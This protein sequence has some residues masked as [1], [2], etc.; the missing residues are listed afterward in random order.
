MSR[1][2]YLPP[3]L[4]VMLRQVPTFTL[5]WPGKP[6]NKAKPSMSVLPSIRSKA[7]L[8]M[9]CRHPMLCTWQRSS[10]ELRLTM[11]LIELS[12][13][14]WLVQSRHL[15]KSR[16][17]RRRGTVRTWSALL[18]SL[19]FGALQQQPHHLEVQWPP[20][21]GFLALA[22]AAAATADQ[23]SSRVVGSLQVCNL[24]RTNRPYH[25]HMPQ[26]V[27]MKGTVCSG[28]VPHTRVMEGQRSSA[29]PFRARS[30]L[31]SGI[32]IG[33]LHCQHHP[34]CQADT[35]RMVPPMKRHHGAL[36]NLLSHR[37]A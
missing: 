27:L 21:V 17:L 37:L 18:E 25:D 16:A 32:C 1:L 24:Q 29:L 5:I 35:P 11:M 31:E 22:R 2:P 23:A 30:H 13:K 26:Q 4:A 8:P 12:S 20:N 28:A 34:P 3:C 33:R 9:P 10:N 15:I 7:T 19:F 6:C 36:P 14:K